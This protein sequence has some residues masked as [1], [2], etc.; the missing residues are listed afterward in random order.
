MEY[1]DTESVRS[2]IIGYHINT[3]KCLYHKQHYISKV[4]LIK[5]FLIVLLPEDSSELD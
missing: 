5:T 2:E 3:E 4:W 1:R